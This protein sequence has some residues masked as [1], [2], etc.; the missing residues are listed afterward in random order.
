M[1]RIW[2]TIAGIFLM[3][4]G[5]T[6][7]PPEP[8]TLTRDELLGRFY[9]TLF[10]L[11]KSFIVEYRQ[12]SDYR[13]VFGVGT[14]GRSQRVTHTEIA[15]VRYDGEHFYRHRASWPEPV[16]GSTEQDPDHT[17]WSW[18][19]KFWLSYN[20]TCAKNSKA[21]SL[22]DRVTYN[23]VLRPDEGELMAGTA[24]S[25]IPNCI[26]DGGRDKYDAILRKAS[27]IDLNPILE[28]VNGSPCYPL[29][30]VTP[31]G[32][33]RIWIDPAKDYSV[34]QAI[35]RKS[36][37]DI[38]HGH[39]LPATAKS[40]M[41]VRI[42]RMEKI[43]GV[44]IPM[45]IERQGEESMPAIPTA[46]LP[47]TTSRYETKTYTRRVIRNAKFNPGDFTL[48][49]QDGSEVW[50]YVDLNNGTTYLSE[51]KYL[52][53]AEPDSVWNREGRKVAFDPAVLQL[54][55][56]K[57]V[58]SP[59]SLNLPIKTE[60]WNNRPVLLCFVDPADLACSAAVGLL[61]QKKP[62]LDRRSIVTAV[63]RAV[64]DP[65]G[66]SSYRKDG[67]TA[68]VSGFLQ[69][70][71]EALNRRAWGIERLPWLVLANTEH[72]IVAEGFDPSQLQETIKRLDAR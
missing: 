59:R 36:E 60:D 4:L 56:V 12:E 63:I 31:Y 43:D 2:I 27:K 28:E 62:D 58:S 23:A 54:P 48:S 35:I 40:L 10:D 50:G 3:A 47:A 42:L 16:T 71:F 39:P 30:A 19:G 1:K 5:T 6:A 45:E 67:D 51:P 53:K 14:D 33:F 9:Q 52:W 21:K 11:G 22:P 29:H 70:N 38:H 72:A 46:G 41:R 18:D 15:E 37:G 13:T 69:P 24:V 20:R 65:A 44:W 66:K 7:A 49:I 64:P 25:I 32:D 17:W 61:E 8:Q 68:I 57:T 55:I 34:T 26:A